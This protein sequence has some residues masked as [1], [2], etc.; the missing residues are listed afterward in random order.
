MII[1]V[2]IVMSS[3]SQS[4]SIYVCAC[5][6]CSTWRDPLSSLSVALKHKEIGKAD[7][8]IY[9]DTVIQIRKLAQSRTIEAS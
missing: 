7:W 1:D 3:W 2:F 9:H 4:Y 6:D 8:L 5:S